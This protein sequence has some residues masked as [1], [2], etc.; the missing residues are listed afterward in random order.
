MTMPCAAR[1]QAVYKLVH[2]FDKRCIFRK[3]VTREKWV[4]VRTAIV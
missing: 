2:L 1:V 4:A 3:T